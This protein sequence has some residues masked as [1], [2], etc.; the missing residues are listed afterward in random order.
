[1]LFTSELASYFEFTVYEGGDTL[2]VKDTP[3]NTLYFVSYGSIILIE[4][5]DGEDDNDAVIENVNT[6]RAK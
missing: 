1:M 6:T 3:C 4:D 2:F 5:E